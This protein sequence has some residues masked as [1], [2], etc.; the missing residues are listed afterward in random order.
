MVS[1]EV[2]V[3]SPIANPM[4]RWSLAALHV[5]PSCPRHVRWAEI[6]VAATALHV[7]VPCIKVHHSQEV[8]SVNGDLNGLRSFGSAPGAQIGLPPILAKLQLLHG[9]HWHG[10]L[11]LIGT[12]KVP[13]GQ[14]PR[15]I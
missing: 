8:L 13:D 2:C 9:R 14:N 4:L 12:V 6:C 3:S 1:S 15:A 5:R 11:V 7:A 10:I